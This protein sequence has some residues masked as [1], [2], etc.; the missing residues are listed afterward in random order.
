MKEPTMELLGEAAI[1]E[2]VSKLMVARNHWVILPGLS[3]A[4]RLIELEETFYSGEKNED[5]DM[6]L[7]VLGGNEYICPCLAI[8]FADK[9]HLD[10]ETF[11]AWLSERY[12]STPEGAITPETLKDKDIIFLARAPEALMVAA[13]FHKWIAPVL[14]EMEGDTEWVSE[15]L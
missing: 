8:A 14:R 10:A 15:L 4:G 7:G 11:A 12:D 6:M 3:G 1:K 2:R 13:D 9:R 5:F